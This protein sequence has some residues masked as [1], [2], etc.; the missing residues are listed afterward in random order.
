MARSFPADTKMQHFMCQQIENENLAR[1]KFFYD[2]RARPEDFKRNGMSGNFGV[3]G[4]QDKVPIF[5]LPKIN[6]MEYASKIKQEE[7]E[8]IARLRE[9]ARFLNIKDE[10]YPPNSKTKDKLYNGF[11][12]EEKGR[13]SYL[14]D[15]R[16]IIP[17][18]K[19]T[20]SI[21]SSWDYGW[22]LDETDAAQP[23]KS[24]FTRTKIVKDSF[25][26]RNKIA[27]LDDPSRG[28]GLME[29]NHAVLM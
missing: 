19:Y 18:R 29:K 23:T 10:M 12:K 3:Y 26:T 9:E 28:V 27:T 4:S 20:Y 22:K 13:Y 11:S 7:Q 15:R 2:Y 24:R 6:P 25:Y 5:G 8:E 16:S 14:R 1:L 21:L 17:E